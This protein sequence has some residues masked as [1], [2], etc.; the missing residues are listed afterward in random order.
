MQASEPI[1]VDAAARLPSWIAGRPR[2]V[3][4]GPAPALVGL[5]AFGYDGWLSLENLW[6]VPVRHTGYVDEDLADV[7][8]PPRDIEQRLRDELAFLRR[9]CD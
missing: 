1:P 9:L 3:A 6:R 4:V 5:Q 7:S 2:P 8:V